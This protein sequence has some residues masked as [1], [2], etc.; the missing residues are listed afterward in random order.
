MAAVRIEPVNEAHEARVQ[1]LA[2]DPAVAATSNVPSPYPPDGARTWIAR[3]QEKRKMGTIFAF[4]VVEPT[5]GLVGV[6]SLMGVNL[7]QRTGSLG[8]WIGRAYWGRGYATAAAQQVVS[9]AFAELDLVSVHATCLATNV[10]SVRVLEKLGFECA[11]AGPIDT[12]G[13]T[14]AFALRRTDAANKSA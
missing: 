11:G 12:R 3:V 13:P 5:E 10:A 8:Y 9:F 14:L 7:A 1:Q 2:T 4:A 6:C